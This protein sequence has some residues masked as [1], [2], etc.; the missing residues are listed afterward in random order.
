MKILQIIPNLFGGGAE[1]FVVDL[2]NELSHCHEVILLTLYD[3]KKEDLFRDELLPKVKTITLG[4][5]LGFDRKIIYKLYRAIKN[6]DPDIIHTHLRSFNYLIPSIPFLGDKK[7]IHTIHSDAFKECPGKNMRKLRNLLFKGRKV[8]PITI[9]R[10]SATS[11]EKAYLNTSHVLIYNGR[12]K[13]TKSEIHNKVVY[14]INKYKYDENTKVFLHI[15]RIE[16][17]KNQL[18]LVDAF[19][20]L[21]KEDHANA[22]L[23][24]VGGKR[25]TE[26]SQLIH[27][28]LIQAEQENDYIH[29]L[30]QLKN[31]G[32]YFYSAD[33]FCLSSKHEGMPITL[34]ESLATGTI[35][36]C[37]PVGGMTEMVSDLDTSLLAKSVNE[38]N[39][40][41]VLKLAYK[42]K[43][44]RKLILKQKAEKIFEDKYSMER[45]ATNHVKLYQN[46]I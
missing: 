28:K 40:Y 18:M 31:V 16:K 1:R 39:Y 19:R 22:I 43:S 42:M 45:C 6:V 17:P 23:L 14:E 37:T 34:I 13:P 12:K 44:E 24:I 33:Y 3:E 29:L 46:E 5:K 35:P 20:R 30:G 36:I 32:D 27:H 7:V 26:S 38:E 21:M 25:N 11:F 10:E 4:K 8:V 2:C 15:G 41:Q 9:S